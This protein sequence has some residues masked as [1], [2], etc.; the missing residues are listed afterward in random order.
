[1]VSVPDIG[2]KEPFWLRI[3]AADA[4]FHGRS[5]LTSNIILL[6][7]LYS[8]LGLVSYKAQRKAHP[9]S[10]CSKSGLIARAV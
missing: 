9:S 7:A 4:I 10:S 8:S 1:M 3:A 2:I 6:L 5:A